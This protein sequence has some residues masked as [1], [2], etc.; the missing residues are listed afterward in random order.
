MRD[1]ESSMFVS[2]W[3]VNP[4]FLKLFKLWKQNKTTINKLYMAEYYDYFHLQGFG[5]NK[6][7]GERKD[8]NYE[9]S[10]F[11]LLLFSPVEYYIYDPSSRILVEMRKLLAKMIFERD[12]VIFGFYDNMWNM[13]QGT[14]NYDWFITGKHTQQIKENVN[15]GRVGL[16]G[17]MLSNVL[18]LV[19]QAMLDLP[20]T[21]PSRFNWASFI[22]NG[23]GRQVRIDARNEGRFLGCGEFLITKKQ[24]EEYLRIQ[25]M[26]KYNMLSPDARELTTLSTDEWMF[27]VRH[28][29]DLYQLRQFAKLCK[30]IFTDSI[31]ALNHPEGLS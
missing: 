9:F 10:W 8:I 17:D 30:Q 25:R 22:I 5:F 18:A 13:N 28:Y 1:G 24:F 20:F 31:I 23:L 12:D 19:N 21:K 14:G 15:W 6:E 3:I 16:N 26:G 4:Q 11:I 27:I 7:F 29:D 2:E